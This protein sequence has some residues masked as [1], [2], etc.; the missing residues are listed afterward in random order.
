MSGGASCQFVTD[1]TGRFNECDAVADGSAKYV[2]RKEREMSVN[3][4]VQPKDIL[5]E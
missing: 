4:C 1:G 3:K 2:G 5:N